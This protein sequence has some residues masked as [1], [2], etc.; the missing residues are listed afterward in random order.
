V[1]SRKDRNSKLENRKIAA[2]FEFPVS[3]F[4]LRMLSIHCAD[5]EVNRNG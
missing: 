5:Y 3:I 4:D 2:R 1:T